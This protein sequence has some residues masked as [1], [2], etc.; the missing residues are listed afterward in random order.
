MSVWRERAHLAG[1]ILFC[2]LAVVLGTLLYPLVL[3]F[4][5]SIAL[6]HPL[7][8]GGGTDG[9]RSRRTPRGAVGA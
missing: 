2:T 5:G 6:I 3:I 4:F 7:F 1:S 8:R 9:S